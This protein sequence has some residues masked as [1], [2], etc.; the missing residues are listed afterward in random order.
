MHYTIYIQPTFEINKDAAF[1]V[2]GFY[3]K[4]DV[5]A[6]SGT[7]VTKPGDLEGY[8]ASAGSKSNA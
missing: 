4:A 7:A 5:L 8:G 6:L 1:F 3:S 2:K